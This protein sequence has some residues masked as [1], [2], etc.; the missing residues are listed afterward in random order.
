MKR[1][2]C[3]ICGYDYDPAV[4]DPS[5]GIGLGTPFEDL[6]GDW[7]CPV[8]GADKTLFHA[9]AEPGVP[10]ETPVSASIDAQPA[11]ISDAEKAAILS[12]LAR[13]YQKQFRADEAALLTQL[14][15]YY[16]T[17]IGHEGD[18]DSFRAALK[19]DLSGGYA[20]AFEAARKSSDRG[21]LRA[22]TW[23]EKVSRIQDSVLGR[24]ADKGDSGFEDTKVFVCDA[25]GFIFL[26]QT[27][28]D[29]CPVCKVPAFKFNEV[30]RGA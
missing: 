25:C 26:G 10:E 3:T 13:G 5:H 12:N 17:R 7:V 4:G 18:V 1:Y 20:A 22:L 27:P 2:R 29:I 6:P 9:L 14:A 8:C 24:W 11:A 23:G 28:P 30:K 15:D 19:D 21:A 16:V